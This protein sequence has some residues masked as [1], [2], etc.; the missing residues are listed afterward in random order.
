MPSLTYNMTRGIDM[1][2]GYKKPTAAYLGGESAHMKSF[3]VGIYYNDL[4][5]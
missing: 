4:K 5:I 1:K 2:D 3:K